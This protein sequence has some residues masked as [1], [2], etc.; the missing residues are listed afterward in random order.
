M[1][2][3][4]QIAEDYLT[5][6]R[7]LGFSLEGHGR[8]V[9]SF[10]DHLDRANADTVTTSL[11]VAWAMQTRPGASPAGCSRRLAAARVFAR[12]LSTVDPRTEV[13]P[14]DLMPHR[15][16]RVTPYLYRPDEIDALIHAATALRH[17][18]RALNYATLIALLTATGMRV[19]EACQLDRDDIDYDTGV[20]TVR[21]G[22]LG[23]AREVPL[24]RTTSQALH[25]YEQQR[26]QLCHLVRTSALFVNTCGRRLNAHHVPDVFAELRDTAGIHAVPGGRR[27]RIHD[28][29]HTFCITTVIDWYRA[30]VDVH[31]HLP[32]LS[33]YLGHVDPVSTYWYLQ[34]A[35]E[36]LALAAD[37]LDHFIGEI[38]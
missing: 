26:D 25:D 33:T 10:I 8:L 29:R 31:A 3:L 5:T 15:Y 22:K 24:H 30:G 34:A 21:A 13:P 19:G 38:P 1:S 14:A 6:R 16:R 17:P 23:K 2:P 7:A 36:L 20:L 12:Y 37:R 9:L 35:P 27:P 28:I 32:L 11:A 18:L 4:R